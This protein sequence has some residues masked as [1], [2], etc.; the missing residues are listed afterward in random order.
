S[1]RC[2]A[3]V[4]VRGRPVTKMGRSIATSACC[5]YCFHAASD[6][7]RATSALRTKNRAILLP[8]SVKPDSRV[9]E[10]S[11]TPRASRYLSSSAPKSSSPHAFVAEACRPSTVPTSV[12]VLTARLPP[13]PVLARPALRASLALVFAPS[14]GLVLPAIHVERLAGDA[15]G[16]IAR[17][18][19]DGGCHLFLGGQP[20]QIRSS[21]GRLVY[22]INRGAVLASLV[23]KVALER[24]APDIA[25][26]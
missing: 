4:P 24:A 18:E 15:A 10:S 20:L 26:Q 16:Q 22:L 21:G 9:Y 19:Q 13:A 8:S 25:G 7:S 17:H 11:S 2:S 1:R 14:S 23:L 5:G 3:V 6:S 12:L